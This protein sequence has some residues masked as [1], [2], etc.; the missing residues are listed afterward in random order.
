MD[1]ESLLKF[2]RYIFYTVLV[3][4]LFYVLIPIDPPILQSSIVKISIQK[5]TILIVV[6]LFL[7]RAL[8]VYKLSYLSQEKERLAAQVEHVQVELQLLLT[9]ADESSNNEAIKAV[10]LRLFN[11]EESLRV[12]KNYMRQNLLRVAIAFGTL[13]SLVGVRSL[14]SAFN[15]PEPE[16]ILELFRFY[17]FRVL[18]V[19]LTAGLIAGGSEGIHNIIKKLSNLFPDVPQKVVDFIQA[20]KQDVA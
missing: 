14:E 18:D 17:L 12:Y 20:L 13:I 7:E 11:A 19:I 15:F 9:N 5:L 8:E 4:G 6:A 1:R 10:K 3:C 2:P 16:S